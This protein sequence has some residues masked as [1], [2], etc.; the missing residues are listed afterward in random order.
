[1]NPT[2]AFAPAAVGD[3]ATC[4]D[5]KEKGAHIVQR[6]EQPA[7]AVEARQPCR[8]GGGA[9][10]ARRPSLGRGAGAARRAARGGIGERLVTGRAPSRVVAFSRMHIQALGM[11]PRDRGSIHC[12][13][14]NL[15]ARCHLAYFM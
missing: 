6:V 5:E 14:E 10:A 8:G 15:S 1:M 4:E 11:D 2:S 3:D 7:E 12:A 9:G 13:A